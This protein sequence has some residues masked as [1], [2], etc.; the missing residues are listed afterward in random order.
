MSLPALRRLPGDCSVASILDVCEADG[1]VI[2][3][4]W[5]NAPFLRQLNAELEPWLEQHKGTDSGSAA[6]DGF[7]GLKTR[8]L[9]GLA[10]KASAFVEVLTEP[11][12][13]GFAEATLA[14]I[15]PNIILNNGEV[16]DIGPGESAQPLHRD[17][18]AWNFA[19]AESPL[20]INTIAALVDVTAAMGATLV[21]PG[22]HRWPPDRM[23]VKSEI[24][25]CELTAGSALFFR[26]D[27]LHAGGTNTTNKRRRVLSTGLC[28]GWLRPV[29]NS[30]TN[31]PLEK[32]RDLPRRAQQLLG[33]ELYDAS[34][35]GGGYLGYHDMSD[36]M[37]LLHKR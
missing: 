13:V 8:R 7:L 5:L 14:P 24:V 31:I 17:D 19:N 36:P 18:D 30:Y 26:G 2:V 21:V 1:G 34:Q 33:Y 32:V 3:E 10:G 4:D 12:L 16:I 27:T 22:S 28:C 9:Q 23:P 6:S 35:V 29:E 20:M 15:S 25:C 11:R 37:K